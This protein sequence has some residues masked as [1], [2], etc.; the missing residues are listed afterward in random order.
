M[1]TRTFLD[2]MGRKKC[3]HISV[4]E[5]QKCMQPEC[6]VTDIE[7]P[8]PMCPT[9]EWS[10]WSPCSSTCG[11]G[12][13]IRTRL[14]IGETSKEMECKQKMAFNEQR[15]CTNR[16]DCIFDSEAAQE[17]C[18]E[19]ADIGP[20]RGSFPRFAYDIVAG[21]CKTFNYGGCRGNK[22]NFVSHDDCMKTCQSVRNEIAED[23]LPVDCQL[24]EWSTWS[25]CSQTCGHGQSERSRQVI[26][27]PKNGG[28]IC[29]TRYRRRRCFLGQC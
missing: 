14:F 29:G 19:S 25:P 28:A 15:N 1:R 23:N 10:D 20:C 21:Q 7:M 5:K 26:R 6:S 13:K 22:N 11:P 4:V 27:E 12:V 8:D 9:T 16:P 24:S 2:N 3:P 18:R 17:I